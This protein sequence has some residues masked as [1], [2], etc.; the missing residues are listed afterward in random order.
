MKRTIWKFPLRLIVGPQSIEMPAGAIVRACGID[1]ASGGPAIWAEYLILDPPAPARVLPREFHIL[2]T[3]DEWTE[4]NLCHHGIIFD[5]QFVWH[6][7]E[8]PL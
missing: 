3:G 4:P 7:K 5:R 8:R 1:P 6:I 2:G